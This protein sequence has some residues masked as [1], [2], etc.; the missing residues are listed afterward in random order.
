[1]KKAKGYTKQDLEE[2]L[3]H[4]EW[5][6]RRLKAAKPFAK[7]FPDLAENMPRKGGSTKKAGRLAEITGEEE[8]K[9]Q[10]Q[11]AEDP[12]NPELTAEEFARARPAREVL[13]PEFFEAVKRLPGQRGPQKAPTKEFV[14]LRLDRKV[15]EHFKKDGEGWRARINEALKRAI[16]G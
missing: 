4:P 6:K 9:I 15:V 13:P 8:A 7:A 11:I 16:G 10:R 5:T 14:S 12:D 2:V 3:D 1:M